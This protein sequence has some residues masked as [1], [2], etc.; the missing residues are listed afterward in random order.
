MMYTLT[1]DAKNGYNNYFNMYKNTQ[2]RNITKMNQYSVN[3]NNFNFNP[4]PLY[5]GSRSGTQYFCKMNLASI[6]IYNR[7]LT[8]EEI[9]HNYDVDKVRFGL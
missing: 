2:K 3:L 8:E 4:Y 6:R 1:F 9:K 7:V 5:I